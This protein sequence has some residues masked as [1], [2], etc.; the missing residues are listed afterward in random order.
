[1]TDFTG[2][3]DAPAR[4]AY[5][6]NAFVAIP[7]ELVSILAAR[8]RLPRPDTVTKIAEDTWSVRGY[9]RPHVDGI[10]NERAGWST[11]GLILFSNSRHYCLTCGQWQMPIAPGTVYRLDPTV[12][13]GVAQAMGDFC[14]WT[15]NKG[16]RGEDYEHSVLTFLAWDYPPG[17]EPSLTTF[18]TQ[19]LEAICERW[20]V[21]ESWGCL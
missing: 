21:P 6:V 12:E 17:E 4:P 5:V 15:S 11:L 8:P 16:E 2:G 13:H 10:G 19:A 9:V 18:V 14:S 7:P 20:L 1:M 3:S